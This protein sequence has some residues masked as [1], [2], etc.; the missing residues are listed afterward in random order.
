MSLAAERLYSLL[1]AVYRLVEAPAPHLSEHALTLH[2][3]LEDAK[4]LL[5]VIVSNEYLHACC[6]QR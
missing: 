3:S 6:S 1:P 2:L 4:R 5:N